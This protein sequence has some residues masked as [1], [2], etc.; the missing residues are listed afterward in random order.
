MSRV[1][2]VKTSSTAELVARLR[3]AGCVFAEDE[4]AILLDAARDA[5]ALESLVSRREAGEPLETIVGWVAFAG[6]RLAVAPRVFVP[7]Q[8]S[9]RI[10]RAAARI[11]A[12]L[13][14][15]IVVEAC[16]GAAPIGAVVAARAPGAR[17]LAFDI[18]PAA[19]AVARTNLPAAE[20]LVGSALA[21][22][23]ASVRGR[24]D[25]IA[26]VPPYVPDGERHLMPHDTF[27]HEPTAALLGGADGLDI[28][29]A[30]IADASA[31]LAPGGRIL[32]ELH[33]SQVPIAAGFARQHG[34][35]P[36]RRA[37]SADGQTALLDARR[38]A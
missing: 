18:D 22:L 2:R 37:V 10:A 1:I 16:C 20:V 24:V 5:A 29:R 38:P 28:A 30:L 11:A 32:L 3:A 13:D 8:R 9:V 21:V 15:P 36:L 19:V 23:P 27:D 34:L 17:I 7:R 6:L 12:G 33:R 4:A 14:R 31:W 35:T 26:A 25:L